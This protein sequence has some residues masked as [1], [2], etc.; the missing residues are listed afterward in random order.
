[1]YAGAALALATSSILAMAP[2]QAVHDEGFA[3]QGNL[4]GT[5]IDWEDLF[6]V[7]G[8]PTVTTPKASLPGAFTAAAFAKD[9]ELPDTT[10]YATGTKDELPISLPGGGD[11]Q[12]KTPNNLGDKF[13]LVNAYAAALVPTTGDDTGDLIVYFGSEVSAPEGNRNMGVW[14]LQ[15]PTVACSGVGNTDF[16]GSHVDG[17]VFVVAAFTGGG[18]TANIDVYEWVDSTPGDDDADV[19]GSLVLKQG[20]TNVTC[21][22]SGAGDDACAIANTDGD[23]DAN[24][25]AFEV[26]PP[27]DAPDKDGGNLNEAQFMEGGVNLSDLGVSGCFPTFLANSRSSQIPGATLHDFARSSF[28]QCG[29][30]FATEPSSTSII[31]GN[32]ITDTAT[33]TVS[34]ANPPAPT[35]NVTFYVC[36]PSDGLSSCDPAN[37]TPVGAV[38]DLANATQSGFEYSIESDPFTPTE[39]GDYCFAASWPGDS[40]YDDGPYVDGSTVECFTVIALQPLIE[41]AQSYYPNDSATITV[42]AGAGDLTGSVRFRLYANSTTCS[43]TAIIDQT[44]QLPAG[45]GQSETVSTTN[46]SV[47]V[48]TSATLSWLV[49]FTSTNTGILNVTSACNV[50]STTLGIDNDTTT[51]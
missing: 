40:V 16:S 6:D 8:T 51:P 36:G 34:G 38:K 46:T 5:G 48:S 32:S 27:W 24:E 20:F 49:E 11:W 25:A 39:P 2:T 35:G 28:E 44:V 21:P 33:V 42:A 41:T 22:A 17:D 37:G 14:L 4:F 31:L 45:A 30:T 9:W 1:V 47:A 10:G 23:K 18:G 43:G 26:N 19:G 7:T 12:C 13:D 29:A 3:L 15:D 50:E